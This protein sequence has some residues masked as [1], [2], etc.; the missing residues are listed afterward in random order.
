MKEGIERLETDKE[1][2][3]VEENLTKSSELPSDPEVEPVKI[4][5]W[6]V[7]WIKKPNPDNP[8]DINAYKKI[9]AQPAIKEWMDNA[10]EL[11][12][13]EE[14]QDM[15]AEIFYGVCGEKDKGGMEGFVWLYK[16]E[17]ETLNNL[18][19]RNSVDPSEFK[20]V[21][22][23]SFARL[24][25]E[26]IPKENQIRGLI[27]SAIR[28]ICFSLLEKNKKMLITA[29]TDPKNLLSEGVLKNAGFV[30]KGKTFY[31]KEAEEASKEDNFWVLDKNELER[32]LKKKKAN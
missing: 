7:A 3:K 27:P 20:D 24:V 11:S 21:L 2:N 25:D 32:I 14:V 26:N 18:K 9:E 6:E 10:D 13:T 29:F 30:I 15:F 28:Q 31:D 5:P 1:F 8:E 16:P 23:T 19:K 22:E 12:T 4:F 17:K